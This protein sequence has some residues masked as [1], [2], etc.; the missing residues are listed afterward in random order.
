MA[1]S[2]DKAPEL[3]QLITDMFG[4]DRKTNIHADTCVFCK[5]PATEFKDE[6][7]RREFSISGICQ[8]CQDSMFG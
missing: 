3:D 1:Q 5:Q 4:I 8:S 2:T 7:S 6:L